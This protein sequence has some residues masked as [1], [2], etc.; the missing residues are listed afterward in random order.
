VQ[1]GSLHDPAPN[2]PP[3]PRQY[4]HP[5]VTVP[6]HHASVAEAVDAAGD[7]AMIFVRRPDGAQT[8]WKGTLEVLDKK[9]RPRRA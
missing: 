6:G 1:R 3:P 5:D 9:A 8:S 7:G 2:P 4:T